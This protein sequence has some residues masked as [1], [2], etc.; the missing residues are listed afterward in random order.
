M[1]D[2]AGLRQIAVHYGLRHQMRKLL[3]ELAELHE[4]AFDIAF[5]PGRLKGCL[6]ALIDEMADVRVMIAE[7]EELTGTGKRVEERIAFK[8]DRQLDRIRRGV[9]R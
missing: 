6:P 7:I 3:E 2:Y 8:I 4:V 1:M 9:E 5:D